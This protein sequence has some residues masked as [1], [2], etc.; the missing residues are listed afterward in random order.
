[1]PLHA[2]V[3]MC[4]FVCVCVCVCVC[5]CVQCTCFDFCMWAYLAV[6]AVKESLKSSLLG[7]LSN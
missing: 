7:L 5:A 4:V 6:Q 3:H 2:C 1:M